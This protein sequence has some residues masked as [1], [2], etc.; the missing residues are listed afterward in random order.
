VSALTKGSSETIGK[1]VMAAKQR[2][3][4]ESVAFD[5]YDE[6]A[7]Q[8]S[9]LYGLPHYQLLSGGLLG[10]E[11]PFPSVV[12]TPSLPLDGGA[13]KVGGLN[14]SLQGALGALEATNTISGTYYSVNGNTDLAAGQPAQPGFYSD[15]THAPAGRVHGVTIGSA[16]YEDITA[17]DPL[18]ARPTNE[19][20]ANWVDPPYSSEGWSPANPVGLQNVSTGQAFTDMVLTQLG[21]YNAQTG[22][23]RLYDGMSLGVY[24]SSSPDWTPPEIIYV[25]ERAGPTPGKATVKV[26]VQDSLSGVMGGQVTYTAGDGQWHS[27]ELA[28]DAPPDKWTAEIP[29]VP[30]TLYFVQMVDN[31]GNVAVADNK[32]R[33]Y[34]LPEFNN[35]LPLALK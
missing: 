25:G 7:L 3:W 23:E 24:Y 10:P 19:E 27:A 8:E 17:P 15:V 20:H 22:Q 9:T 32:G 2:Y 1:A 28:Y 4:N 26:G 34:T 13:V 12:I 5:A 29:A 30:H 6:K 11:D 21:Q 31:G 14:F 18:I 35:Y 16:H 33:Y